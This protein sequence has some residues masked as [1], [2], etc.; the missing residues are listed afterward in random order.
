MSSISKRMK[1]YE[2]S[3]NYV[4]SPNIPLIIRIDGRSFHTFTEDLEKPFDSKFISMM[5]SIGIALCNEITGFKLAYIQ[6][7]EISLL[8]YANSIEESWFKNKF[9]K[10]ISISAGLASAVGM[11]WKY[12][13]NFKKETIITFDSRAFVIPQNDVINYFIWR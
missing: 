7:D 2:K 3:T 11:Q 9:Y 6:S 4:L 13:N 10:I 5:N 8:I 1:F 12:K